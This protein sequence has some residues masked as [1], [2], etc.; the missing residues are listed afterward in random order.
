MKR[1]STL[2]IRTD[3]YLLYISGIFFMYINYLNKIKKSLSTIV[4]MQQSSDYIKKLHDRKIQ[5]HV[6]Y[7]NV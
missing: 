2:L 1:L 7:S 6:N 4:A 3:I 5:I